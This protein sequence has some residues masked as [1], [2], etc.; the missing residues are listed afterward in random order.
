MN[1]TLSHQELHVPVLSIMRH[2]LLHP[3]S[4]LPFPQPRPLYHYHCHARPLAKVPMVVLFFCNPMFPSYQADFILQ[5]KTCGV[6]RVHL[7]IGVY[8]SDLSPIFFSLRSNPSRTS[9]GS[10][11]LGV[12]ELAVSY[13]W[14]ILLRSIPWLPLYPLNI[15]LDF[16]F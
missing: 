3:L 16:T 14:S 7:G 6:W 10:F 9:H 12:F 1:I 5:M 8:S 13:T 2:P 15:I 4:P 11:C